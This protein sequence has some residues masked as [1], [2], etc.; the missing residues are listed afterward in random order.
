MKKGLKSMLLGGVIA[1]SLLTS[2]C[3]WF[4]DDDVGSNP[5]QEELYAEFYQVA[6]TSMSKPYYTLSM[7]QQEKNLTS[8]T[9]TQGIMNETIDQKGL[10]RETEYE[11]TKTY[12][13]AIKQNDQYVVYYKEISGT[14][15]E[16]SS[17]YTTQEAFDK[18]HVNIIKTLNEHRGYSLDN[19]FSSKTI[20]E[21]TDNLKMNLLEGGDGYAGKLPIEPIITLEKK[22]VNQKDELTLSGTVSYKTVIDK[23][24]E[25]KF[26]IT[27]RDNLI[28]KIYTSID[29]IVVINDVEEHILMTQTLDIEYVTNPALVPSE[30]DLQEFPQPT[31]N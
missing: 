28:K 12:A 2:G 29:Y 25:F 26:V 22:M 1:A 14:T 13:Y 15:T 9:T 3:N 21:L 11:G 31:N 7:S 8:N 23:D 30:E 4:K 27:C 17:V 10:Y 18:N 6:Q 24:V 5:T 16:K 19:V 20:E